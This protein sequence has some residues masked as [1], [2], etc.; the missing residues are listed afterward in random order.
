MTVAA[1]RI[2]AVPWGIF[3]FNRKTQSERPKRG[4]EGERLLALQV[5]ANVIAAWHRITFSN[6]LGGDRFMTLA[7]FLHIGPDVRNNL[8][9]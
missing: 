5:A 3:T 6:H 9:E 7:G 1:R 8:L 2:N 4:E